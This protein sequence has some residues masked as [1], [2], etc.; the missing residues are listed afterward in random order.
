MQR[1]INLFVVDIEDWVLPIHMRA[2]DVHDAEGL[3]QILFKIPTHKKITARPATEEELARSMPE[4]W[5]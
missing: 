4:L 2:Y 5:K 1:E 3:A